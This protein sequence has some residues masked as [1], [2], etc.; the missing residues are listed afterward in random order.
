MT[1]AGDDKGRSPDLQ[2]QMKREI[3][4]AEAPV[5]R[6]RGNSGVLYT[7][8]AHPRIT[9][10]LFA[11]LAFF[12]WRLL[13]RAVQT[14]EEMIEETIVNVQRGLN[15]GG[16]EGTALV[17]D[18]FSADFQESGFDKAT[19]ALMLQPVMAVGDIEVGDP[20]IGE[21]EI[22]GEKAYV[23]KVLV[24]AGQ[25]D[26]GRGNS[27]WTLTLQKEEDGR[28]RIVEGRPI[29]VLGRD[30]VSIRDLLRSYRNA[31]IPDAF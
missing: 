5:S 19:L 29:Q 21:I 27:T 2:E 16:E 1:P 3:R 24:F 26:Y 4:R 22:V 28:W 15:M 12:A 9:L 14:D 20:M 31:G 17:L 23:K 13:D 7:L 11:V 30:N 10:V 18:Q 8:R 6:D 25:A